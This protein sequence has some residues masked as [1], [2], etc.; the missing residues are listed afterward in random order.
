MNIVII[1]AG[2]VGWNVAKT[3]SDE[4]HNIYLIENNEAQAKKA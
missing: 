4:G 1:G 3:L 2:E